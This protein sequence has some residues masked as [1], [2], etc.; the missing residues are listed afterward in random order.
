M[1]ILS[2][3]ALAA[4]VA[5]TGAASAKTKTTTISLDGECD[6]LTASVSK[7]LIYGTDLAQCGGAYGAGLVGTVKGSGGAAVIGVQSSAEPGVQLV[8][9]L[10][11]PF[12]TGG[13]WE[14]YETTD[15]TSMTELEHGTYTVENGV[16]GN[17][18]NTPSVFAVARH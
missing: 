15:G 1:R 11:Y 5:T 6:V 12:K 8:F 14:L 9:Q 10:Q 2:V 7:Q 16:I 4:L 17:R 3:L 13:A 18:P